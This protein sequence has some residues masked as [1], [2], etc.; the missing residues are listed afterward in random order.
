MPIPG[1][2]TGTPAS[3]PST[4]YAQTPPPFDLMRHTQHTQH[5][6]LSD[7]NRTIIAGNTKI[8]LAIQGQNAHA[9]AGPPPPSPRSCISCSDA[10]TQTDPVP[11]AAAENVIRTAFLF[12]QRVHTLQNMVEEICAGRPL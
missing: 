1:S 11:P 3:T 10:A 6:Q 5:T 8:L 12:V 4:V 7:L 9:V 2:P